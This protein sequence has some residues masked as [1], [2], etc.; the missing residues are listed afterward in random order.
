MDTYIYIHVCCINNWKDIF[1]NLYNNIK[2]SG[3][4]NIIKSIKCNI[5]KE[6]DKFPLRKDSKDGYRNSCKECEYKTK[7]KIM[8]NTHILN[9]HETLEKRQKEFKY[10]CNVCDFGTFFNIIIKKHNETDKHKINL[11]I[12]FNL[13]FLKYI[14]RESKIML[15]IKKII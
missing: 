13:N 15:N 9:R 5:L 11:I 14:Y 3:L 10:Y 12:Y 1:S 8:M 6:Y 7:N 4:Y 2:S